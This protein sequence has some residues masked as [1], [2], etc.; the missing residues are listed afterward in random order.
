MRGLTPGSRYYYRI[1]RQC[2]VCVRTQRLSVVPTAVDRS[3]LRDGATRDW[4]V[5]GTRESNPLLL[6][7]SQ[8]RHHFSS[9]NDTPPRP[10]SLMVEVF[11]LYI[12]DPVYVKFSTSGALGVNSH[13]SK[14]VAKL[15]VVSFGID[16]LKGVVALVL[17][18]LILL[19]PLSSYWVLFRFRFHLSK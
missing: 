17:M 1:L 14:D 16:Y 19:A 11:V 15:P 10:Q 6:V 7:M 18:A 9:S 4:L 13:V 2:C 5:F 12:I 8:A 3:Q